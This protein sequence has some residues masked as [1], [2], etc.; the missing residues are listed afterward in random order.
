MKKILF[1]IIFLIIY[2]CQACMDDKFI[3]IPDDN[4]PAPAQVSNVETVPTPGGAIITYKLPTDPS[5]FY[6]KA[7]YETRPGVVRETKSSF[8]TDRIVVEGYG[9]TMDHEVK[10]YS[11]GKNEKA[12]E[13]VV[14]HVQ[15]LAPAIQTVFNTLSLN[16]TFGGVNVAFQNPDSANLAIEVIIDTT[17]QNIWSSVIRYY[18]KAPEGTFSVRGYASEEK[19][20]GVFLR[21]RWSNKSDTLIRL[22]TP[23]Y[24]EQISRT[25]I[26]IYK[27]PGDA[28]GQPGLEAEKMFDGRVDGYNGFANSRTGTMP[29]WLTINLGHKVV[30]SRIREHQHSGAHLYKDGAVKSFEL[31][32]SNQPDQ[33]GGWTQWT[34]LGKFDSWKPSGSAEGVTTPEDVNYANVLGEEFVLENSTQAFQYI[35]FKALSNYNGA[36]ALMVIL[37]LEFW[38]TIIP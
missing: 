32:G 8:H 23:L 34:L 19:K 1:Y 6:V 30:I 15:P 36:D 10:L 3:Q 20:F 31:W 17:A 7:V 35:R 11:V 9:D 26:S 29:Q 37:E 25:D 13:P 2:L 18:T 33:D 4:T 27:L 12:S 22:L 21:D 28:Q 16:A 5:L 38:G 14:I 24:E